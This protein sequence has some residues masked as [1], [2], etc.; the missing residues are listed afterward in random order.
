MFKIA[1]L[2]V[3]TVLAAGLATSASAYERSSKT[4]GAYGRTISSQGSGSCVGGSCSS[5]QSV[6]GPRG[7][8]AS[9]T[10]ATSCADGKCSG[11]AT[12]TGP[13]GNTATRTRSL[14]R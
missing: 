3:A 8:T 4:T 2:A 10:G 13:A 6:T 1:S 12:I 9:R 5:Q 11:S 14:S 7:N